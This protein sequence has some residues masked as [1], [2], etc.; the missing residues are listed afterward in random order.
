MDA[1]LPGVTSGK[2][3]LPTVRTGTSYTF[4]SFWIENPRVKHGIAAT[5][6]RC[7]SAEML[8]TIASLKSDFA[9]PVQPLYHAWLQMLLNMDR[10][11]LWGSAGGMVFEMKPPGTP[12]IG[13]SGWSSKAPPRSP[14]PRKP[15][16]GER[17]GGCAVQSGELAPHRSAA[18]E[19][20]RE[21]HLGGAK[22]EAAGDGTIFCQLEIP[23][24]GIVG[25]KLKSDHRRRA[26]SHQAAGH[27]RDEILFREN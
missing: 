1:L 7:K 8:A 15:L 6:T 5:S 10:N 13:S 4:D 26:Q 24:T 9:Y 27:H 3:E 25:E 20:S 11:T 21:H 2:I 14:P 17:Q 19:S 16:V 22:C 18:P 23:A 12:R